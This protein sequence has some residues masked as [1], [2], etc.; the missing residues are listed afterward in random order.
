MPKIAGNTSFDKRQLVVFHHTKGKSVPEIMS[1]LQISRA[2]VYRIIRRFEKEDRLEFKTP[3][4]RPSKLSD[5]DERYIVRCITKNPKVS[6]S[7]VAD[8]VSAQNAS[9]ISERTIRRVLQKTG[10]NSRTCRRK[11]YI[12]VVNQKKNLEF[13]SKYI[14]K[15]ENFWDDVILTDESK[16][17][18]F[19][20]DGKQK[21][22][23]NW[24]KSIS[25]CQ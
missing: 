25:M 22:W 7:K 19:G 16:Y 15:P 14:N 21:V 3:P 2:T 24:K 11:F 5:Q 9:P 10:Y 20:S 18:I 8:Q 1:M 4:G 13:A 17:N 6:A 23:R 12:S